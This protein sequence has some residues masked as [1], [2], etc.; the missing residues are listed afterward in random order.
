MDNFSYPETSVSTESLAAL[1]SLSIGT[2]IREFKAPKAFP[3]QHLPMEL[4]LLTL[5]HILVS[6]APIIN[7]S[8]PRD[9]SMYSSLIIRTTDEKKDRQQ[10]NPLMIFTCKLFYKEGLSLLYGHNTFMYTVNWSGSL[11]G[12]FA[13]PLVHPPRG[14]SDPNSTLRR[15][16]TNIN[17][18]LPRS[19]DK[20][21]LYTCKDLLEVVN[22]FTNLRTL[23]IDF[24]DV[25]ERYERACSYERFMGLINHVQ[26]FIKMTMLG[27]HD[28]T[29][30]AGALKEIVLTDLPQKHLGLWAVRQY[31][32]LLAPNG[33]IGVGWGASGRRYEFHEDVGATERDDLELL[34]MS[35]EEAGKWIVK[36]A[37]NDEHS[38]RAI[39]STAQELEWQV[40]SPHAPQLPE[41]EQS[42][43]FKA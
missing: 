2:S 18:R 6:P 16:A 7:P 37:S 13:Y 24:L 1:G 42:P 34:W 41:P 5:Q 22:A 35:A 23:Q 30:P 27:L 29:R 19:N 20:S 28:P 12:S 11:I 8:I 39:L 32:R 14:P 15:Q 10:F 9:D 25:N 38:P 21:F 36:E 17:L 26:V 3:I 40:S 33:R 43:E 31:T 4:Q